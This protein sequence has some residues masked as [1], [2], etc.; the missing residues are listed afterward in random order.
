MHACR[1]ELHVAIAA[2]NLVTSARGITRAE[3]H[4]LATLA[5]FANDR[6]GCWPSNKTLAA[7]MGCSI[8]TVQRTKRSLLAKGLLQRDYRFTAVG[9]HT[10]NFYTINLDGLHPAPRININ[11]VS[12]DTSPAQGSYQNRTTSGEN[13][14]T[15]CEIRTLSVKE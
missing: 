7:A 6:G 5:N 4:L 1:K 14:M 10:S 15:S 9:D 3:K 11:K 13:V 12:R 8:N 2:I